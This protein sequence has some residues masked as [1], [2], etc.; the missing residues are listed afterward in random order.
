M[1]LLKNYK[2]NKYRNYNDLTKKQIETEM[3]KVEAE[4]EK[5]HTDIRGNE[6]RDDKIATFIDMLKDEV[7]H[8]D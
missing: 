8:G 6:E 3:R 2:P 1:F 5:I 7:K 4:I